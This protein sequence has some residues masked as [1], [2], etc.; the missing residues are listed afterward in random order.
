MSKQTP[1]LEFFGQIVDET[2]AGHLYFQRKP[3]AAAIIRGLRSTDHP[4]QPPGAPTRKVG[5]P[6]SIVQDIT[7]LAHETLI[8]KCNP[9]ERHSA[10]LRRMVA[11]SVID[12]KKDT[13]DPAEYND[14]ARA[15][16]QQLAR[17][18]KEVEGMTIITFFSVTE[19]MGVWAALETPPKQDGSRVIIDSEGWY[20][21]SGGIAQ[22][23]RIQRIYEGTPRQRQQAK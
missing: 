9:D 13:A 14:K 1:E 11:L 8:A 3:I 16:Q 22:K 19:K 21:E 10:A 20:C 6:K 5:R 12:G 23:K 15:I 4:A 2:F 18:R 17:A 7:L